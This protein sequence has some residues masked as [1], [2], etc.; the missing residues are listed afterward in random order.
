ML[1]NFILIVHCLN[2]TANVTMTMTVTVNWPVND[3][4]NILSLILNATHCLRLANTLMSY[5]HLPKS[6]WKKPNA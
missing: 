3:L 5:R 2:I 1:Q 6:T 4:N